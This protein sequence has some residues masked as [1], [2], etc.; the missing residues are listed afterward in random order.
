MARDVS[1][2]RLRYGLDRGTFQ[3]EVVSKFCRKSDRE[4]GGVLV[5]M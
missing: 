1:M 4:G 3:R 5:V 2:A